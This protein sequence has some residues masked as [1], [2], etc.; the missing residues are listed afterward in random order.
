M[1]SAILKGGGNKFG[2]HTADGQAGTVGASAILIVSGDV[3]TTTFDPKGDSSREI[4][5]VGST[6]Y[7]F[8]QSYVPE[9][10]S[11]EF[12]MEDG[13]DRGSTTGSFVSIHM[14]ASDGT[15]RRIFAQYCNLTAAGV[16]TYTANE[17]V[18]TTIETSA[19]KTTVLLT[20]PGA[21]VSAITGK[22]VQIVIAAGKKFN[23][24]VVS[25]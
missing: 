23:F 24:A 14:D 6:L 9:E 21:A 13:V 20:I 1:P 11:T 25:A 4:T 5:E 18:T 17:N 2:L 3:V 16:A 22:S 7:N 12:L 8:V 15:H 19:V 10:E